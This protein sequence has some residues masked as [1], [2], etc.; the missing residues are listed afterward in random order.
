MNVHTSCPSNEESLGNAMMFPHLYSWGK[1]GNYSRGYWPI[2]L[3]IRLRYHHYLMQSSK[4]AKCYKHLMFKRHMQSF[5]P[6]PLYA[7]PVKYAISLRQAQTVSGAAN[8]RKDS[9]PAFHLVDARSQ[10]FVVRRWT[11]LATVQFPRILCLVR[12]ACTDM[13][14]ISYAARPTLRWR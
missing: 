14:Q 13:H 4:S 6:M 7:D 11:S 1:I 5:A 8:I 10:G 3:I 12:P 9:R 2:M